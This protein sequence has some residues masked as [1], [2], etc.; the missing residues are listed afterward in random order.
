MDLNYLYRRHGI[1]LY[2]AKNASTERMRRAHEAFAWVF[3]AK[4]ADARGLRR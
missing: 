3:A 1:S 4:I 2:L